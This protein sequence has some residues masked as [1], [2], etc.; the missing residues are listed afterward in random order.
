MRVVKFLAL[1][2]IV[3]G[4]INWGLWGIFQYDFIADIFMGNTTMWARICYSIVG[5]AGIIGISFFF[6]PGIYKCHKC[7]K[8]KG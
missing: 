4:A 8:P 5:F 6:V 2:L 3:A 1:L 7:E